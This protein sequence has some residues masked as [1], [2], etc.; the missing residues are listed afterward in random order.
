M[1]LCCT[2]ARILYI[3]YCV[4]VQVQGAIFKRISMTGQTAEIENKVNDLDINS[5]MVPLYISD[6]L[7]DDKGGDGSKKAPF[8]TVLQAMRSV[9]VEPFPEF[10]VDKKEGNGFEL[11]AKAQL[12]K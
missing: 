7:G 1:G 3:T 4:D 11:I 8:K 6:K 2:V 12:K 10:M 9:G 5:K